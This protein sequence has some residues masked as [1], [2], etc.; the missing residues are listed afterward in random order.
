MMKSF[1]IRI[2]ENSGL[3]WFTLFNYV[4]K[5]IA[6]SLPLVVLYISKDKSIY[7]N[8]EYI[9]SIA[10]IIVVF[11]DFGFN[12][13]LFYGYKES[14]DKA[15]F[16]VDTKQYFNL[17]LIFYLIIAIVFLPIFFVF[18]NGEFILFFVFA[19]LLYLFSI[20]FYSSF[21]RLDDKPSLIYWLSIPVNLSSIL[22]LFLFKDFSNLILLTFFIPQIL[23][24]CILIIINT[25]KLFSLSI[26]KINDFK[27]FL[28][29]TLKYSWPILIN[30][31]L[32][33]YV[34]NF[35]KIYAY[36]YLNS[37]EMYQISYVLRISLIIQMAHASIIAFYSKS[38]YEEKGVKINM[39]IFKKYCLFLFVAVILFFAFIFIL[40]KTTIVDPIKLNWASIFIIVY[41]LVWCIRSYLELYYGKFNENKMILLFSVLSTT[42]YTSFLIFFGISNFFQLSLL[43]MISAIFSFILT[44]YYL[45][46][47]VFKKHSFLNE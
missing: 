22:L 31:T 46:Y 38:I 34:N 39:D 21:F 42:L 27:I 8:I 9:F 6:F 45:F 11:F 32:I 2:K 17:Y 7:N 47:V 13:Y 37:D 19:R 28:I 40:N 25:P 43:M 30:V 14:A 35:G 15:N 4:D 12:T 23:L 3:F 26:D 5:F 10:S 29:K 1:L 18:E 41:T 20:S 24:L 16:L 33:A 36:N 44:A